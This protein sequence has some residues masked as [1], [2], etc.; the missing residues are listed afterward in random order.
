MEQPSLCEP[1]MK[2]YLKSSLKEC[3]KFRD[4]HTTLLFN[5]GAIVFLCISIGGFLWYRYKG[6]PS[7]EEVK[8]KQRETHSYL[9]SKLQQ[10]TA[11]KEK[12]PNLITDLPV[13]DR[14]IA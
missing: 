1:G 5:I 8:Q 13:W 14:K 10:Y 9:I 3:K 7:P 11:S 12:N 4:N 2:Y 6:K